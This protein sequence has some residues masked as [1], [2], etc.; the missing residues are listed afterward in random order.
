[1]DFRSLDMAGNLEVT[2]TADFQVLFAD[3]EAPVTT[4]TVAVAAYYASPA[5]ISFTATDNGGS[6]VAHTYYSLAAGGANPQSGTSITVSTPGRHTLYFWSDDNR[7]NTETRKSRTFVVD[8]AAPVTTSDADTAY[9][10]DTPA[11]I[12]LTATDTPIG[13]GVDRTFYWVDDDGRFTGN[14]VPVPSGPGPHHVDFRSMDNAGNLEATKT[15]NFDVIAPDHEA[16][17]TTTAAKVESY[18]AKSAVISVVATDNGGSGVAHTYFTVNGGSAV[19]SSTVRVSVAGTYAITFWSV[20]VLGNVEDAHAAKFTIVTP[21]STGGTPS[22]P[23]SPSTVKHSVSF[24][25]FGYVV[26]H[27]SGTSPVSLQYYRLE[28]GHWV[29]RKTVSAKV[30]NVLTFSKY[31]DSTSVPYSGKWRVRARHKVGSHYHYSG[32]RSFTA[33]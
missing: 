14:A 6:G 10:S 2:R 1:V 30:T 20:D 19:D 3:H 32:Y 24:T 28:H 4:P 29:L 27:T 18:Y 7:G 21:P 33:S 5:T 23:S 11:T 31:G 25:A 15:A 9:G 8:L 22:T 17:D 16:P 12:T 13:S 26:R